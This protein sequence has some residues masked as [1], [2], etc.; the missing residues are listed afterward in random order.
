MKKKDKKTVDCF[1]EPVIPIREAII[2]AITNIVVGVSK[3][4]DEMTARQF[5]EAATALNR[6]WELYEKLDS[7]EKKVVEVSWGDEVV[8]PH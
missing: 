2:T 5:M 1:A 6:A 4:G 3:L 7:E 8:I